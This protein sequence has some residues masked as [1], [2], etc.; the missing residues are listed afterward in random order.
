MHYKRNPTWMKTCSKMYVHFFLKFWF[1]FG[2]RQIG[3]GE[4]VSIHRNE[5]FVAHETVSRITQISTYEKRF[6]CVDVDEKRGG[7]G[8]TFKGISSGSRTK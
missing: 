6:G 4:N 5:N 2:C 3:V 7:G 8:G 1:F